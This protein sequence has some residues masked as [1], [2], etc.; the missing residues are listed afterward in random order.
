MM[1]G[2]QLTFH[3]DWGGESALTWAQ[4]QQWDA[5]EA[6]KP[7]D[8]RFNLPVLVELPAQTSVEDVRRALVLSVERHEALRTRYPVADDGVPVQ[9]VAQTGRMDVG[10]FAPS[11][12]SVRG[13]VQIR[14][15]LQHKRFDTTEE[16]PVRFGVV[17]DRDR[18]RWLVGTVAHVSAD[19]TGTGILCRDFRAL[20]DPASAALAPH[21]LQPRQQ[22]D[23]ERSPLGQGVLRRS[24]AAW[25]AGLQ[26]VPPLPV[27]HVQQEEEEA[28]APRYPAMLLVA[29]GIGHQVRA[30]AESLGAGISAPC[31]AAGASSVARVLGV[32]A[33]PLKVIC[34]NRTADK[35][36]YV[37]MM[38]QQGLIPIDTVRIPADELVLRVWRGILGAHRTSRYDSIALQAMVTDELGCT[39]PVIDHWINFAKMDPSTDL[40]SMHPHLADHEFVCEP[41][42]PVASTTVR[43][44]FKMYSTGA[45]LHMRLFGDRTYLPESAMR[46]ILEQTYHSIHEVSAPSG[47]ALHPS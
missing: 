45:D 36:D 11:D 24:L 18:P 9:V 3:G 10:V 43:I 20:L 25:R 47:A 14:S 19:L 39:A 29:K 31:V 41:T 46:S 34:N 7:H 21:P 42:A 13:A 44:G 38:S 30:Y 12:A 23:I 15:A 35:N 40:M 6:N 16:W 17:M 32:D 4:R 2:F 8:S 22:A 33:F 26:R 5:L 28:P 27:R 1:D 37:G